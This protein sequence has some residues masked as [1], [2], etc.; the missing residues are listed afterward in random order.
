MKGMI[1]VKNNEEVIKKIKE[2]L[3]GGI[4]PNNLEYLDLS[5]LFKECK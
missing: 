2:I 4:E 1:P 5:Y 3:E